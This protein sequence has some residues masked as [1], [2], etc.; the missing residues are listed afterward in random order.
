MHIADKN[1]DE[2]WEYYESY[3]NDYM[4]LLHDYLSN[5]ARF[6]ENLNKRLEA[7]SDSDKLLA[8]INMY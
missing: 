4:F 3:D 1:S 8:M 6:A 2:A 5:G 7:A